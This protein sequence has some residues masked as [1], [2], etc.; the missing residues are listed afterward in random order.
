MPALQGNR[1]QILDCG[2]D[3]LLVYSTLKKMRFLQPGQPSADELA[4]QAAALYQAIPP[5]RLARQR[6][7]Q[8]EHS[9]AIDAY[10][11][12][13]SAAVLCCAV[14]GGTKLSYVQRLLSLSSLL[15]LLF[16]AASAL[17]HGCSEGRWHVPSEP[18]GAHRQFAKQTV[19]QLQAI[20][21]PRQASGC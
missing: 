9:A 15:L 20:F 16:P 4:Q 1:Q 17:V 14:L 5:A 21:A 3:G 13:A 19:Q 11:R 18:R 6:G 2:D 8:L 10:L 7:I 12:C